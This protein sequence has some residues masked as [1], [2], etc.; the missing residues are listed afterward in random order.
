M[1]HYLRA[2]FQELVVSLVKLAGEFLTCPNDKENDKQY[3]V[4]LKSVEYY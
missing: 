3:L 2:M 4:G 1:A